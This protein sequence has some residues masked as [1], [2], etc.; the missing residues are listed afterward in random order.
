[1]KAILTAMSGFLLVSTVQATNIG[2]YDCMTL[3]A[4]T[5]SSKSGFGVTVNNIQLTDRTDGFPTLEV[6]NIALRYSATNSTGDDA[7]AS[8]ELL[9][10]QMMDG[11][12]EVVFSLSA[13]TFAGIAP[14]STR[15]VVASIIAPAGTLQRADEVCWRL[16]LSGTG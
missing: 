14:Q 10:V 6:G 12:P 9:G 3:E 7:L 15:N 8:M 1:M 16:F 11:R 13:S 4:F 5:K 2:D